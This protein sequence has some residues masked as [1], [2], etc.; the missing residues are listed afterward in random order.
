MIAEKLGDLARLYELALDA[1][2]EA[3][4]NGAPDVRT[5]VAV[6]PEQVMAL[7][8]EVENLRGEV[9]GLNRL[10]DVECEAG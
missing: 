8:E 4:L 1:S 2:G 10:L 5:A 3:L 6:D 7:V 9:R